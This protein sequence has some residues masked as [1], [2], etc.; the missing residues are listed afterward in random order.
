M[1]YVCLVYHDD[2]AFDAAYGGERLAALDN[3]SLAY[4]KELERKGHLILAHALHS[5]KRSRVVRRRDAKALV[6]DGPYTESKEQLIGFI[7]VE[8]KDIAEAA[9]LAADIP[10]ARTGTIV[11]REAF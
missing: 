6:T 9:S 2:D 8:A 10:L 11:V 4:D 7:V 3:E 5:E 1:Q